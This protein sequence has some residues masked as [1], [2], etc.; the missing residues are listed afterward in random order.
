MSSITFTEEGWEDYLVWQII[1]KSKVR[2]INSLLK[3]ISRDGALEGI[4][5]PEKLS[6]IKG[7]SRRIDEKNRL[8]YDIEDGQIIVIACKGHYDDK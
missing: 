3:S 5:K 2:R 8:V 7:F 1:D 6:Y 4:G